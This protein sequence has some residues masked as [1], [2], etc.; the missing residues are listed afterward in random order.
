MKKS[1]NPATLGAAVRD[2]RLVAGISQIEL[3]Q[4]IGAS[5]FWVAQFEKG[6]PSAEL[7]L[8]LKALHALGLK[9][10]VEPHNE[11]HANDL[12]AK[13]QAGP[14]QAK[15]PPINLSQIISASMVSERKGSASRADAP[16]RKPA[17]KRTSR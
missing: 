5:R 2:A 11:A 15:L 4:R 6:K 7:G 8:A 1:V 13:T 14:R 3:G 17:S 16:P 10:S 12:K 9:V